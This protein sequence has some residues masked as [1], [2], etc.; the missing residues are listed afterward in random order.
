MS[1]PVSSRPDIDVFVQCD[2]KNRH[3]L[4]GFNRILI[5]NE[6]ARYD[7]ELRKGNIALY[8]FR[9]LFSQY[10]KKLSRVTLRICAIALGNSDST[11]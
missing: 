3:L 7:L 5:E 9:R 11:A 8:G 10:V 1:R 4:S 2:R 6:I